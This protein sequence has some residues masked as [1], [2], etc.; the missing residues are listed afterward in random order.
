MAAL[1]SLSADLQRILSAPEALFA[2]DK[3]F[4]SELEGLLLS[5]FREGRKFE[6]ADAVSD[7]D[8]LQA[9]LDLESTWSLLDLHNDALLDRLRRSV[10]KLRK[11]PEKVVLVADDALASSDDDAEDGSGSGA[12]ESSSSSSS[13]DQADASDVGSEDEGTSEDGGGSEGEEGGSPA[14]DGEASTTGAVEDDDGAATAAPGP[15]AKGKGG[16]NDGFFDM[17]EM[18]AFADEPYEDLNIFGVDGTG[19]AND[20]DDDEDEGS[21]LDDAKN[22][23]YG[24]YFG[25]PSTPDPVEDEPVGGSD[26]ERDDDGDEDGDSEIDWN[27]K[28]DYD[29]MEGGGGADGG[30]DG[31]YSD[32][33]VEMTSHERRKAKLMEQI[34]E[35]EDELV[36]EKRW[37]MLGEASAS[38]RPQ[39]SLLQ[40]DVDV[41]RRGVAAPQITEE[42]TKTLEDIIKDRIRNK[43]WDD[44]VPVR[45]DDATGR[46][47]DEE[48][49]QEKSRDG[50][51]QVYEDAYL[52]A[53]GQSSKDA[54]LEPLK[55]EIAA[56]FARITNKIDAFTSLNY[57]AP[58]QELVVRDA[59]EDAPALEMEEIT[60]ISVSDGMRMAPQEIVDKKK[61]RKGVLK[62]ESERDQADRK[63]DR[64]VA[65]ERK[66]KR[67]RQRDAEARAVSALDPSAKSIVERR[68]GKVPGLTE[69]EEGGGGNWTKSTKF[70]SQLQREAQSAIQEKDLSDEGGAARSGTKRRKKN[71]GGA[72]AKYML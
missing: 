46:G 70:F 36:G 55:Q 28:D 34:D 15:R 61:G 45:T 44:V 35:L 12:E 26:E 25:P 19:G 32:G 31:G 38:Q 9:G 59:G 3:A 5:F 63:R 18:E 60:P 47:V 6:G 23:R 7:V 52:D 49:S 65:K 57:V 48:L 62:G 30:S 33:E 71:K 4:Q 39:D 21:D 20:G 17:A 27:A 54:K 37:D 41:D 16:V 2:P 13:M 69:A 53:T 56:L 64:R 24:D 68:A 29:E 14:S 42:T 66:R 58:A 11:A 50:L 43:Q 72:A 22:L 8:E 1:G 10:R 51:G 40:V 67:D